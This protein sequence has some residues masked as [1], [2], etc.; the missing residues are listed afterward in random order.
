MTLPTYDLWTPEVH[1][2]EAF[3]PTWRNRSNIFGS[4]EHLASLIHNKIDH[5][6]VKTIFAIPSYG[7]TWKLESGSTKSGIAPI[8][9]LSQPGD[10][11]P[12]S[13]QS[14]LLSYPEICANLPE[15]D[16]RIVEY[17]RF[18]LTNGSDSNGAYAYRLPDR[19]G[20]YGI[21]IGFDDAVSVAEK[22]EMAL[23]CGVT[24]FALVDLGYDDFRGTCGG[25]RF[26]LLSA[27]YNSS[28]VLTE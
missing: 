13:R 4:I 26:P 16:N 12:L 21:W 15:A 19:N 1:P 8:V 2:D 3:H 17:D 28:G 23:D 18:Q 22:V 27:I 11:G 25:E 10:A 20:N 6:M 5:R 7:R 9:G 24:G 14:G